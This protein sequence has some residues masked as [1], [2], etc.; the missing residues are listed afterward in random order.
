[1]GILKLEKFT[2][3]HVN[4]IWEYLSLILTNLT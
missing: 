4:L 1:M 2:Y 3:D